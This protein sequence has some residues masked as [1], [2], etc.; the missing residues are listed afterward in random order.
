VAEEVQHTIHL[1][2]H[3][4][5]VVDLVEEDL[6]ILDQTLVVQEHPVKEMLVEPLLFLDQVEVVEKRQLV[7]M[8]QEIMVEMG[9]LVKAQ[10]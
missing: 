1:L 3:Q 5:L 10:L 4:E 8:D 6:N 2:W 7:I 9:V